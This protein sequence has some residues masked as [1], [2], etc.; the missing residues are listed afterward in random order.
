VCGKSL[1]VADE[2]NPTFRYGPKRDLS[3]SPLRVGKLAR[4][5]TNRWGGTIERSAL[6]DEM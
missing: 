6:S 3:G 1:R 4:Q 2:T 5:V